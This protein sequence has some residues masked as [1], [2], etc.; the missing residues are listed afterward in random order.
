MAVL[1]DRRAAAVLPR[2]S[3]D[4][5]PPIAVLLKKEPRS[6]ASDPRFWDQLKSNLIH[7]WPL[8]AVVLIGAIAVA[9]LR[10]RKTP[11]IEPVPVERIPTELDE[12]AQLKS[13]LAAL[14]DQDPDAAAAVLK[15]WIQDAA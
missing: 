8:L 3:G 4:E 7:Q 9:S 13:Q 5:E 11:N 1:E 10:A 12:N 14:I 2:T 6:L 15:N